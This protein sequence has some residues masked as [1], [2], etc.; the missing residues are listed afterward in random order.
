MTGRTPADPAKKAAPRTRRPGKAHAVERTD[1][2]RDAEVVLAADGMAFDP[3]YE[4]HRLR[5]TGMPWR[6]VAHKT[7]YPDALVGA[8]AVAC[9]PHPRS[10]LD[11]T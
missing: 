10:A 6:E 9:E 7:G 11:G 2:E 1:A 3:A 8:R 5:I 4:A